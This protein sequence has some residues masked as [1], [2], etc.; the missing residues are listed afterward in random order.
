M[1]L[2]S[3]DFHYTCARV[4]SAGENEMLSGARRG[5]G[6]L[7]FLGECKRLTIVEEVVS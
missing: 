6:G 1:I 2:F 4:L 3:V 7:H 5:Q